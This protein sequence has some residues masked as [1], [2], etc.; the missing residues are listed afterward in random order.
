MLTKSCRF[1]GCAWQTQ[2]GSYTDLQVA[3]LQ[4]MRRSHVGVQRREKTL[5]AFA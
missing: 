5:E 4:H 3:F 2:A 1:K